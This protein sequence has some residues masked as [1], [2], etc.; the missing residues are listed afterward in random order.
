MKYFCFSLCQPDI[1]EELVSLIIT[2]PTSDADDALKYK[3]P[4]IASELLTSDVPQINDM[5]GDTEVGFDT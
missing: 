3:Y 5:L 2:D 4:N 1:I